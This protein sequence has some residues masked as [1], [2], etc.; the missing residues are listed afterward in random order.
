MSQT[1]ESGQLVLPAAGTWAIDTSHSTVEFVVRHMMV[2]KVRGRFA[3]FGGAIQITDDPALSSVE[4]TMQAASIDSHDRAR[5]DHLRSPDFLAVDEYPELTF[6]S[7]KVEG[8]GA[9]WRVTGDLTI[10]GVT[11]PVV[12]DVEYN[13]VS[14]D[15]WGGER[16]GF[17]ATT[18]I[19]R[20]EFGLTWNVAIE[21]GGVVVGK[22][23][24]IELEIE[25][26]RQAQ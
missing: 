22:K 26:V 18:E 24:K 14:K 13:G 2:S 12:L 4:V 9:E 11:R 10:K 16:A 19:D 7:T 6:R 17:S 20:E 1:L 8:G 21:T 5:D 3:D 23:V 25:A 15:P